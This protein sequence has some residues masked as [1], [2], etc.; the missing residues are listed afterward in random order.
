MGLESFSESTLRDYLLAVLGQTDTPDELIKQMSNIVREVFK[1]K[2]VNRRETD[3]VTHEK[4]MAFI[5]VKVWEYGKSRGII[6][7][8]AVLKESME[9]VKNGKCNSTVLPRVAASSIHD[10]KYSR[11]SKT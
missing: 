3:V 9:K 10:K 7:T 11:E 6:N 1:L 5:L 2:K 8:I 4:M